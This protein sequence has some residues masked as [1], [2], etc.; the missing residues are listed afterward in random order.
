MRTATKKIASILFILLGTTP[1]LFVF[2]FLIRQE[3]IRNDMKEE[4]E[5]GIP[6]QVLV[7]PDEDIHWVK[8]GKE[9]F[10]NSRMF[11]IKTMISRNGVT[12]F[13]GLY[14]DQETALKKQLSEGWNKNAPQR[15]QLLVQLIFSLQC[16]FAANSPDGLT[17]NISKETIPA[18]ITPALPD[19]Y[20]VILTPPP[21][22]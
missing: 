19:S 17:G 20:Q 14:D 6:R 7:I 21:Q 13:T 1:W 22:V 9:I 8:K 2:I 12:T 18:L 11:D 15:N 10:V 3:A 16:T 4:L 5:K